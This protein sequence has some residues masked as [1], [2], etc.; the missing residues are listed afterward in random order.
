MF[1]FEFSVH[2]AAPPFREFRNPLR[3][4]KEALRS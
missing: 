3:V 4:A 1:G 2:T